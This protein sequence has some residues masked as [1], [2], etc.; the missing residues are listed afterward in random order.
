MDWVLE[1]GL[2]Y[3]LLAAVIAWGMLKLLHPLA[4]RL[5]LLD[6]PQGRKDHAHPT[7]IIGGLA[8]VVGCLVV[9]PLLPAH[10]TS[11]MLAFL[12]ASLLLVGVGLYDDRHDLRWYWRVLA[13][14]VAALI[15]I[16]GAG[17]RVANL[18][19]VFGMGELGWISVPF[20]V[21]A[22]VGIINA[23]NMVDGADGLA[24]SLV[25]ACLVMLAAA[26]VYAGN[27]SLARI[28]L[29]IAGAVCAFLLYNMRFPWQPRAK[30]FMGNAGSAWLGLLV[31][32]VVFRLTQ[33]SGHPVNPVLA[34]WLIP[35][36]V[37]DCLVLT[38]RR[39]REGR[40]PFSAGRDHIHHFMQDAG[41]GPTQAALTLMV[42]S[43]ATGAVAGQMM[44]LDVPNMAILAAF[45]ALCV[46]WYALSCNRAAT[47]RFFGALRALPVFGP[48]P[49][50]IRGRQDGGGEPPRAALGVAAASIAGRTMPSRDGTHPAG[51]SATGAE[52]EGKGG[53]DSD[54]QRLRRSA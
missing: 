12:A 4:P 53:Q 54:D 16:Y 3:A 37:M 44:R 15:M 50:R 36:P 5:N 32:W 48:L 14:V 17:V 1:I 52:A 23:I 28:S 40:S 18:G 9:L 27:P 43:F 13:Q 19:G 20:T 21:F 46:G 10:A 41:F 30:T 7:P 49:E 33:N 22:T 31:A 26:A 6:F 45:V 35:I 47:L 2:G 51:P 25:A 34:L 11:T 38:V 8:M 29:V 39:T 24:G 42:F